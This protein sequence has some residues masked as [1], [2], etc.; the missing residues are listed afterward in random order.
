[1]EFKQL[2]NERFSERRS[3]N[4][5]VTNEEITEILEMTDL[6]PS[7]GNLQS[8][9]VVVVRDEKVRRKLMEASAN[10][11]WMM[12]APVFL[13]FFADLD[14]FRSRFSTGHEETIALQD[15]S[16]AMA[17]A[18]LAATEIGLGTCWVG[19]F[20]RG[21]A[22]DICKLSGNLRFAGILTLGHPKG[23]K[24]A[25]SRRGHDDWASWI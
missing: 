5:P 1:M 22:Q 13:V 21:V 17:Y 2:I 6:A 3:T 4:E 11:D 23:R 9:R 19:T 7:A 8:F 25:R 12:E 15:A 20:A 16:I 10:Q 14:Q 18:Q 24:P